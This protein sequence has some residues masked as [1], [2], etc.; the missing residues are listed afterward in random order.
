MK[1]VYHY[2]KQSN[3]F[4]CSCQYEIQLFYIV[5]MYKVCL[6]KYNNG[7]L[8]YLRVLYHLSVRMVHICAFLKKKNFAIPFSLTILVPCTYFLGE[9]KILL[10]ATS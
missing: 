4:T 10:D 9:L 8:P 5:Y 6:A 7:K 3:T 1:F 2:I